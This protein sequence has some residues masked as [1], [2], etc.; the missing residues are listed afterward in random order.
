MSSW[1]GY[2][3]REDGGMH[4]AVGVGGGGWDVRCRQRLMLAQLGKQLAHLLYVLCC[5]TECTEVEDTK[6]KRVFAFKDLIV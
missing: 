1:S 4:K 3:S 6:I 2:Q 5:V